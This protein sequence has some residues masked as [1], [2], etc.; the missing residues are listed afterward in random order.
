MLL[1][2]AKFGVPVCPHAGGVGLCEHVQHFSMFDYVRVS[3][4]LDDR[5]IEYAD[6]LHEHFVQPLRRRAAAATARRPARASA[7]RSTP[8]RS[9]RYRYPDGASGGSGVTLRVALVG[10]PMYDRL[11]EPFTDDVEVVVHADHPTLN[12]EVA[13]LLA[14]GERIDVLSTHGKYAP[15]QARVAAP[16]R[17]PRRP[18][19]SA[20]SRRGRS[21]C[22]GSTARCCA[23]RATSTCACS[24]GAP[25][26]S[27]RRPTRGTTSRRA[28]AV[29]GFTGRES[30][31]FGLFFELV[32]GAA[33]R[34]STPS[35]ARR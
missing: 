28:D 14:P 17:R 7:S 33:A 35:C 26:C 4:P 27:T 24:G 31:L 18:D 13:E 21:T 30:G 9:P 10:G 1:L 8:S 2:A 29:F 12:R 32:V 6:H 22:A 25:T 3:A 11:Y 20:S 23:R 34:C 5:M 15:S 19:V 16:A